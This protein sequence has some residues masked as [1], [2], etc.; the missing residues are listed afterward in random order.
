MQVIK[1][2]V[3]FGLAVIL[4]SCSCT[5]RKIGSDNIPTGSEG[6]VLSDVHFAFDSY[7]LSQGVRGTLQ[8]H[9]NWLM[10]NGESNVQIEGHCDE[11]GT[12][13]Y[14]LA[15]GQKR[16]QSVYEYL[17]SLGVPASRMSTVSYG[18]ELPLDPGH[19][20]AAWSKNRRAH[21]NVR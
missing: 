14:N 4:T 17:K 19:T 2:L 11:R 3:V 1:G 18:E 12:T 8:N 9:A 20:E 15:L 16:A 13:Q 21:F 6:S 10:D 7:E 5:T